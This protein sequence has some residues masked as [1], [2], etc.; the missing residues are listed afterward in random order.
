ML[1]AGVCSIC[2]DSLDCINDE[3]SVLYCGH[4]FHF[5]CLNRWIETCGNKPTCPHCRSKIKD[6]QIVHKIF[7]DIPRQSC[8][9]EINTAKIQH[10][11][12]EKSN[13]INEL[14]VELSKT[15]KSL[16]ESHNKVEDLELEM[17]KFK[18]EI[19]SKKNEVKQVKIELNTFKREISD[20]RS[21]KILNK[22]LQNENILYKNVQNV[23]NGQKLEVDK[24]LKSYRSEDE[25]S[26]KLAVFC[27]AL[28]QEYESIKE[29]KSKKEIELGKVRKKYLL[30]QQ[31][32]VQITEQLESLQNSSKVL[33]LS[34]EEL[35]KTV[36]SLKKK[37]TSLESAIAS[38]SDTKSSVVSRLLYE[39][40]A[41]KFL[42]ENE[43]GLGASPEL[44][45]TQSKVEKREKEFVK[46][47]LF[48]L[49]QPPIESP[50]NKR[51]KFGEF[52]SNNCTNRSDGFGG[53]KAFSLLSQHEFEKSLKYSPSLAT[54]NNRL[55]KLKKKKK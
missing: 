25:S 45:K 17:E 6:K 22:K 35:L 21:V 39:S 13:K 32:H 14:E 44:K 16:E 49:Q 30:L 33:E 28:K 36:E 1:I 53:Q 11:L 46:P 26:H 15:L 50:L 27:I 2:T 5:N 9:D 42:K 38:P 3:I 10:E 51:K 48:S 52:I 34:E 43:D 29:S 18:S 12:Q 31:K 8:N 4:L 20:Y 37:I 23:L 55:S 47:K 41:P 7:P 24:L 54:L 19:K 40:P